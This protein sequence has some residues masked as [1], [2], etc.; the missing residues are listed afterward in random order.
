MKKAILMV[1]LNL[2]VL[3][4]FSQEDTLVREKKDTT[5]IKLGDVDVLIIENKDKGKKWK[6]EKEGDEDDNDDDKNKQPKLKDSDYIL[7]DLGVNAFIT[8]G[9][10]GVPAGF[11]ELALRD[12]NSL[13]FNLH[14]FQRNVSLYRHIVN[15][16]SGLFLEYNNFK[17]ENESVTLQHDAPTLTIVQDTA[18]ADVYTKSKL[19]TTYLNV[20]LILHFESKPY[21]HD[22]SVRLGVGVSAGVLLKAHT[23]QKTS[24][25]E[26]TKVKDDFNLQRFK[27]GIVGQFGV[28]GLTLYFNY[29]LSNLFKE[30]EGP[31]MNVASAGLV[32]KGFRF[33]D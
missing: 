30:S 27:Y 24:F 15:L 23:K 8:D 29:H 21:N 11:E 22:K 31:A 20:P 32:L 25:G 13:N 7:L 5:S 4:G 18:E 9:Q 12:I 16:R 2:L 28:G 19:T 33:R 6:V 14:L 3:A 10:I 1:G 26:K 17:F